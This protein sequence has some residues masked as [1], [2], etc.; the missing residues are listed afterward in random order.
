M[1]PRFSAKGSLLKEL[2]PFFLKIWLLSK[3][4]ATFLKVFC[5][6]AIVLFSKAD[7]L[8]KYKLASNKKAIK[9]LIALKIVK[10]SEFFKKIR[11]KQWF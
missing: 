4:K 8:G 9:T 2:R 11:R 3:T 6:L 10:K 7:A 5:T 1:K